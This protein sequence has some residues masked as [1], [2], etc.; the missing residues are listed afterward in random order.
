M[1]ET[2]VGK[3]LQYVNVRDDELFITTK[4]WVEKTGYDKTLASIE[5]LTFTCPFATGLRGLAPDSP[6]VRRRLWLVAGN[7]CL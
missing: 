4:V 5:R 3:G 2:E 1:N 6:S 7:G